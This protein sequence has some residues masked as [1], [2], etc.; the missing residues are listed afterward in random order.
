MGVVFTKMVKQ[1]GAADADFGGEG[2]VGKFRVGAFTLP[3]VVTGLQGLRGN[4][5]AAAHGFA[6]PFLAGMSA[7]ETNGLE[8]EGDTQA[9]FFGVTD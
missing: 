7:G 5:R 2:G 6:F 1:G 4:L 3:G 9:V 8:Q